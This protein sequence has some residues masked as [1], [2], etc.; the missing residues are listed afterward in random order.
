M[1]L[2]RPSQFLGA[3][4]TAWDVASSQRPTAW[5]PG[6]LDEFEGLAIGVLCACQQRLTPRLG[7]R[8]DDGAGTGER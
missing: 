6:V 7:V 8:I 3:S 2:Y 5:V 4:S 1:S